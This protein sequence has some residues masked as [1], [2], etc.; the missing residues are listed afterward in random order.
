MAAIG[1]G[2]Q[3]LVK[4]TITDFLGAPEISFMDM[5]FYEFHD[6]IS[7]FRLLNGL[8]MPATGFEPVEGQRFDTIDEVY[9]WSEQFVDR[10]AGID[11]LPFDLALTRDD[12]IVSTQFYRRNHRPVETRSLGLGNVIRF[13]AVP[14]IREEIWALSLEYVDAAPPEQVATFMDT[15]SRALP[16]DIAEQLVWAVRSPVHE[17]VAQEMEATDAPWSDRIVRYSELAIDGETEV[18]SAAIAVGRLRIVDDSTQLTSTLDSDVLV[19]EQIPDFL[20]PAAAIISATPQTP[21]AHVSVLAR[22]RGIPSAYVAGI[23]DDPDILQLSGPRAWVAVIADVDGS[24]E[25]VAL[26][27]EQYSRWRDATSPPTVVVQRADLAGLSP[28][29]DLAAVVAEG[30]LDERSLQQWRLAIGGKATGFLSLAE[31]ADIE[32]PAPAAAI[33]VVPYVE[34]MARPEVARGVD[35]VL[36]TAGF[37]D[38]A[39]VRHLVLEGLD[40]HL[41][42]YTAPS[43]EALARQRIEAMSPTAREV[44]EAGGLRRWLRTVPIVPTT[45]AT[46]MAELELLAEPLDPTQGLRFRSSSTVED[47]DGFNGAGLYDSNTGFLDPSLDDRGRTVE[48]AILRTWASYW[49]TAAVEERELFGVDHRSG[50]MAILV[51]P[52]FDDEH[53]LANGV[54]TVEVSALVDADAPNRHRQGSAMSTRAVVTVNVQPGAV[55]VVDPAPGVTPERIVIESA[56]ALGEVIAIRTSFATGTDAPVMTERQ[57]FELYDLVRAEAERWLARQNT[58]RQPASRQS[59]SI[60]LDLEFKV[61]SGEWPATADGA[62]SSDRLVIKQVRSLDPALPIVPD[63]VARLAIPDDLLRRLARVEVVR[64]D[65]DAFTVEWTAAFSDPSI[66]PDLGMTERGFFAEGRLVVDDTV[67]LLSPDVTVS[68]TSDNLRYSEGFGLAVDDVQGAATGSFSNSAAERLSDLEC[69]TE[70]LYSSATDQL[71]DE[72]LER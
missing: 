12:R 47:I 28:L 53:E 61:M 16:A 9:A 50:S 69:S 29:V 62:R 55:S 39:Q 10:S 5:N 59:R 25:I 21:L 63:S 67:Y 26:T 32:T 20:P 22:N 14:E 54:V 42:R 30:P 18:Y 4:F 37:D 1:A 71:L 19:V 64:C 6:E 58:D 24:V 7:W 23:L 13:P 43:D 40:D 11:T 65:G 8:A 38:E 52:R 33:S 72:I 36:A 70:L 48:G 57:V 34:H 68:V 46:I 17:A 35:A 56:D 2:G 51:H 27:E 45:L 31:A 3:E 15:V 66:A 41:S 49:G 60:T 44:V